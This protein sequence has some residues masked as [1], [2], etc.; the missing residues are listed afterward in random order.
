MSSFSDR[1]NQARVACDKVINGIEDNTIDVAAAVLLCKK[2]ARLV[3]DDEGQTW[4]EYEY[5]GYPRHNDGYIEPSAWDIAKKHGRM[6]QSTDDKG[7]KHEYI[8]LELCNELEATI[9]SSEKAIPNFTTQGYSVSGDFA[10]SATSA[11]SKSVEIATHGLLMKIQSAKRKLSILQGQ[12]YDYAVKWQI[13]LDFGNVAKKVFEEYQEKIDRYFAELPKGTVQKLNAIENLM[14][15]GN[16]ERYAQVLTSCRRLWSETAKLLFE[17]VLPNHTEK[18]YKTVSGKEID[19]SGDHDNNKLSAVIETLQHKSAKNTIV[20]SEIIYLLDW[21]D[22]INEQQSSGVHHDVTRE[23]A[24]RCIIH[25]YIA[26]GDILS[27]VQ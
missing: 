15:D 20:G 19:I 17:K 18:K 4:L 25:T 8:F 16:P 14:E 26:L 10:L 3:N 12:Y 9:E 1:R 23:V 6:Y 5:A 27:L 11:L 24:M 13:E 21:M 2:I 7:K 22:R